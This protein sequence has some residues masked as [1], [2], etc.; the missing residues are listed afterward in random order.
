MLG[1][2]LFEAVGAIRGELRHSNF[3]AFILSPARSHG[4]GT[5][6]FLQNIS[7]SIVEQSFLPIEAYSGG[8]RLP[9]EESG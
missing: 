3:L 1:F 4:L 7:K 8:L 9:L 6:P 5:E 2:N